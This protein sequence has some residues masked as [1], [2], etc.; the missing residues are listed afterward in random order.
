MDIVIPT[1]WKGT[2]GPHTHDLT[3]EMHERIAWLN[4][5]LCATEA[6]MD[7]WAKWFK[8][9]AAEKS[10]QQ[11]EGP[12]WLDV[13]ISLVLDAADPEHDED[14]DNHICELFDTLALQPGDD[15][16]CYPTRDWNRDFFPDHPLRKMPHCWLTRVVMDDHPLALGW[17]NIL[18]IGR[19]WVE[20]N[21]SFEQTFPCDSAGSTPAIS[22]SAP[23]QWRAYEG[24]NWRKTLTAKRLP[25]YMSCD[26]LSAANIAFLDA[27]N[28]RLAH[29]ETCLDTSMAAGSTVRSRGTPK[30]SHRWKIA[31]IST[32][33][34][35]SCSPQGTPC[36]ITANRTSF[37]PPTTESAPTN[38]AT[39]TPFCPTVKKSTTGTNTSTGKTTRSAIS[40]IAGCFTTCTTIRA[41]V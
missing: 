32:P 34:W 13:R 30:Q 25:G 4:G 39:T 7:G 8:Q 38:T 14:S 18:R 29:V 12:W 41:H 27:L 40:N 6:W 36:S 24:D 11:P 10:P 1:R 31:G 26:D 17:K 22:P 35:T 5:Q 9:L 19:I 2:Q 28:T 23:T 15:S 37:T 20:A 3:P 21:L 16:P 33:D